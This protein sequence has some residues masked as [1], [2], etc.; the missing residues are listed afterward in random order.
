MSLIFKEALTNQRIITPER[1]NVWSETD[2]Y[3]NGS[4][5]VS[6]VYDVQQGQR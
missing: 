1:R 5:S 2:S 3:S 4:T 6:V